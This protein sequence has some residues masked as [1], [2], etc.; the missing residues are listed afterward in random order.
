AARYR[1]KARAGPDRNHRR[2]APD[3]HHVLRLH[4]EMGP[5]SDADRC[6]APLNRPKALPHLVHATLFTDRPLPHFPTRIGR[7]VA[8]LYGTRNAVAPQGADAPCAGLPTEPD[9]PD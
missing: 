7:A 5:A 9:R 1:R 8:G 6:L 3:E 4:A 2:A